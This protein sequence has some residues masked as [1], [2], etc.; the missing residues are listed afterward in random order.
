M[1]A[2]PTV[3]RVLAALLVLPPEAAASAPARG[4]GTAA[5]T[6]AAP[7]ASPEPAAASPGERLEAA[8]A[9]QKQKRHAE[10]AAAFEALRADTGSPRYRQQAGQAREAAGHLAHALA[11]WR[12]LLAEEPGMS[13]ARRAEVQRQI[14]A[15]R[16]KT[17]PVEVRVAAAEADDGPPP[18]P[19]TLTL[20]RPG[21]PR[22]PLQLPLPREGTLDLDP[23]PWDITAEAA[24]F[25]AGRQLVTVARA[26]K[27]TPAVPLAL[28]RD[29]RDVALQLGPPEA[30]TAGIGLRLLA[31][32]G[33]REAP[34]NRQVSVVK[35][36]AEQH[37]TL[38]PGSWEVVVSAPGFVERTLTL[39]VGDEPLPAIA[40][41]RVPEPP[42][43]RAPAP[44]PPAPPDTRFGLGLGLGLGGGLVFGTGL[45]L[46]LRHRRV[47]PQFT[48]APDNAVYVRAVGATDTGAA[49]IG[50]GLGL[51]AT[52]LTAGLGAKDR[53]LWGELAGGGALAI[54]GAAWY[55]T[56]W[57]R[58]QKMLYDGGKPG[59][60]PPELAALRRET[61]AAS[62]IGAGVGLI[63]G[64]GVALLTRRLVGR[65]RPARVTAGP[66]G[67]TGSF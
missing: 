31:A 42:R 34:A 52:A 19:V 2:G 59:A 57:Q 62:F 22:P 33:V 35:A 67:I 16:R 27:A 47:Y 8:L 14:D 12:A 7:K 58:V 61:A 9:L 32:D 4:G 53:V 44:V 50:G 43:P 25:V 38:A 45:G 23:G 10:A 54:V 17:I 30:V 56:E 1:I 60:M 13:P 63:V 51:G 20:R 65:G 49:L 46:V 29:R 40:L 24:G 55:V 11:H 37:L 3:A 21:D 64:S 15:V 36:E 18:D 28:A 41:E 66:A 6:E 48:P 26:G 5:A 39:T